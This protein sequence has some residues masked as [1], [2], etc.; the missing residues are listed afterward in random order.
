MKTIIR[1]IGRPAV[2]LLLLSLLASGVV[3]ALS[4]T[5]SLIGDRLCNPSA[6]GFYAEAENT[7]DIAILGSSVACSGFSPMELWNACGYTAYVSA[8]GCQSTLDAYQMLQEILSCQTPR[9]VILET[10]ALFTQVP[11]A[12]LSASALSDGIPS[13]LA[14]HDRRGT[15]SLPSRRRSVQRCAWKGQTLSDKTV[16]YTGEES[17]IT[18]ETPCPIPESAMKY[19]EKIRLLCRER[20]ISLLLVQLPSASSWSMEK[21]NAVVQYAA[22][23]ALPFLDLDCLRGEF[24]FDWSTDTCDGGSHLNTDGARKV[25]LYLAD[26]LHVNYSLP[27]HRQE[28]DY[29][30]WHSD[31][32]S[33]LDAL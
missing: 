14:Q 2:F 13:A 23:Y 20:G 6:R 7:I 28:A 26:Y 30:A 27:D 16:P 12:Q 22:E 8:E 33:Y 19:L 29:S 11:S 4:P 21:H 1:K 31:Y 10:D 18:T 5:C 32:Q 15:S 17:L 3:H 24:S 9:L 25:T